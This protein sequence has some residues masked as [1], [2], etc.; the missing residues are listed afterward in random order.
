[1]LIKEKENFFL[2]VALR[3]QLHYLL[4]LKHLKIL[5]EGSVEMQD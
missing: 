5:K 4:L 1:M 2:N 3:V